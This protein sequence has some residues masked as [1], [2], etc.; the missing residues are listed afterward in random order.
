MEIRKENKERIRIDTSR[1]DFVSLVMIL[2]VQWLDNKK[3]GIQSI[4]RGCCEYD[5]IRCLIDKRFYLGHCKY[6]ILFA[7]SWVF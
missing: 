6:Q 3:N 1:M 2:P 5:S 4:L 7:T